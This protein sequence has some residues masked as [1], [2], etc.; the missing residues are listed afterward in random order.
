MTTYALD[1]NIVSYF[2]KNDAV[3][4]QKINEEKDKQNRFVIPPMVYF[5]IQCWLKKNKSKNKMEIFQRI[6]A[7][8][9]IGVIDKNVLDIA[10]TERLTLQKKGFNIED[11]DLLIAA[12]CINHNLPLVTNNTRHFMHIERL[13]ILNW[14]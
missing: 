9:G 6:Y 5:E 1:T 7:D 14:V 11:D 12:Y 13:K 4:V 3:I 8:Q 2:L 10:V